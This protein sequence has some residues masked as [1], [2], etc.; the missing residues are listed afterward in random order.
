MKTVLISVGA[1]LTAAI[2]FAAA[3][4]GSPQ[5]GTALDPADL[6]AQAIADER[7]AIRLSAKLTTRAQ[8]PTKLGEAR[9]K[10]LD[11]IT[12]LKAEGLTAEAASLQQ[13]AAKDATAAGKIGKRKVKT[14]AAGR[15]L[16]TAALQLKLAVLKVL[17]PTLANEF[18]CDGDVALTSPGA[19]QDNLLL[20]RS[21]QATVDAIVIGADEKPTKRAPYGARALPID[22][23]STY[24][25]AG[26]EKFSQGTCTLARGIV[27]CRLS[28]AM[29][30]GQQFIVAFGPPLPSG[31]KLL[32]RFHATDG[33]QAFLQKAMP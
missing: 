22:R 33:K 20:V 32:I 12:Q 11:A 5:R 30:V 31:T 13:A 19:N 15:T 27:T 2:A 10:L 6:V 23:V 1:V 18:A 24:V 16:V 28:S 17:N 9:G 14:R 7:A 29:E 26:N 3:A 4:G 21:C 8:A 25:V